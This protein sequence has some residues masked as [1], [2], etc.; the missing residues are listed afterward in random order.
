MGKT[1]VQSWSFINPVYIQSSGTAVGPLEGQGPLSSTFD[2]VHDDLHCGED[3]WELAERRLMIDA[4]HSCLQKAGVDE[5]NV[6]LFLAGDLLNQNVTGNYVAR[7][8]GI[9]LLGMFGACSTSMETL[10]TAAALVEA[11]YSKQALVAVSS[12][13]ATAERQF[14]Y[15]TEYGGQKP[16]TATFTVTGSGAALVSKTP[17]PVKIEAATIGKVM[18]YKIKDPF[19]MGS[20][21]APAAWDT[22]KTHLEDMGRVPEDYDVIA[23]GD[24][25]SVGTPIL[26]DLMKQDGYDITPV[27]K[28]CGLMVYHSDQ[29]VF[30]GGSGCACSA[31]VTYGKLL[32]DLKLGTYQRILIVATGALMS[33][34]MMQQ[35]ESIPGIAHAVVLTK[36]E[37]S[38]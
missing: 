20:A 22:I 23:T 8:L 12:H 2:R 13:N 3:N 27:H 15:P 26:R 18:D 5:S 37:V 36:G 29:P 1:G 7:Q 19:D 35:K 24:L 9:P 21:M 32:D 14:R 34:T 33:P 17:S 25:S 11:G 4:V 16:K 38:Q 31:V 6:D 10:A 28:D 30:S